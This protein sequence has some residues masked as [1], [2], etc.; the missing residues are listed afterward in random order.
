[1]FLDLRSFFAGRPGATGAMGVYLL[2]FLT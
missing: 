2:A 1:V